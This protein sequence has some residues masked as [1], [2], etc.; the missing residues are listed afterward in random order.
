[1][2]K[3]EIYTKSWCPFSARAKDLLDR[4]GVSYKE[5][6]VTSDSIG[7][8][9]MIS[10]SERHTVPQIFIDDYHLGGSDDLARAANNGHLDWLLSGQK[11]EEAA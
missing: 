9:E 5:I 11:K 2:A 8:L 1:M 3:V 10:R 7:E 6:D 4:K